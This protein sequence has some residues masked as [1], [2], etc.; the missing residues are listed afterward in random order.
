MAIATLASLA[1]FGGGFCRPFGELALKIG[2]A[3]GVNGVFWVFVY[4]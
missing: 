2:E 4:S 3:H 1:L